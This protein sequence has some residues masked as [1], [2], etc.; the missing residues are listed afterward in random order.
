M[1]LDGMRLMMKEQKESKEDGLTNAEILAIKNPLKLF[2]ATNYKNEY[3]AL[4]MEYHPDHG[5]DGIVFSHITQLYKDF[6]KMVSLGIL[7]YAGKILVNKIEYIYNSKSTFE[8]GK[9]YS[10][11]DFLIYEIDESKL[12]GHD[13]SSI[14][15]VK[16]N[17]PE[18]GK[19]FKTKVIQAYN[20]VVKENSKLYLICNK[21]KD[22]FLLSDL[23]GV[24]V[25]LPH[26]AW[27]L[28]RLYN[29]C[30]F[31]QYNNIIHCGITAN[32]ILVKPCEHTIA[33]TGGMWYTYRIGS[34]I[35]YI[36]SEIYSILPFSVIGAKVAVPSIMSE[37][38]HAL[39]REML[40][41]RNA[42]YI[43]LSKTNSVFA[44]WLTNSGSN[45]IMQ[46]YSVWDKDILYSIFGGKRFVKWD[47]KKEDVY[48]LSL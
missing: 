11:D 20:Q 37:S 18:M 45:D 33:L 47:L 43:Q 26:V 46:E 25:N 3:H 10:C 19:Q 35:K 32:N 31:L 8:L 27:I 39:G 34:K 22:E 14:P 40:G 29:I 1:I 24:K 17:T 41:C 42:D 13:I 12:K 5:G 9:I 21:S 28:S 23:V 4:S 16:Y 6:D 15:Q 48:P 7:G 44:E 2:S 38:I 36:S 30:S